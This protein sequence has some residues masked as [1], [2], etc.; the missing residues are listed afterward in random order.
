M[1]TVML[2]DSWL[3]FCSHAISYPS[4]ILVSWIFRIHPRCELFFTLS[5][6]PRYSKSL[7]SPI[8]ITETT[9]HIVMLFPLCLPHRL[10]LFWTEAKIW[11]V[12]CKALQDVPQPQHLLFGLYSPT[13]WLSSSSTHS[14]NTSPFM[15][16]EYSRNMLPLRTEKL[17]FLSFEILLP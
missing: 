14:K 8:K 15:C 13:T 3:S 11:T 17:L 10:A 7:S 2:V 6:L 12:A 5:L 4:I 9:S 1:V 16:P